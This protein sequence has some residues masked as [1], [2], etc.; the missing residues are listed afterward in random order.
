MRNCDLSFDETRPV[1]DN[2]RLFEDAASGKQNLRH[3]PPYEQGESS[4]PLIRKDC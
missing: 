2:P 1:G 3:G 4:G